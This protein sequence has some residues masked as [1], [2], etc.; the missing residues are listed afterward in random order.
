MTTILEA[1][2]TSLLAYLNSKYSIGASPYCIMVANLSSPTKSSN[3]SL[4]NNIVKNLI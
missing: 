2:L 1:I 4:P 3:F